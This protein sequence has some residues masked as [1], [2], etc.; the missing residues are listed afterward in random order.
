MR[1]MTRRTFLR[2]SGGLVVVVAGSAAGL[3][4]ACAPLQVIPT[5]TPPSPSPTDAPA[6]ATP[7][8]AATP[9]PVPTSRPTPAFEPD[10]EIE[11][12]AVEGVSQ[13]FSGAPTRVWRYEA[14]LVRGEA[15]NV[16]PIVESYLGPLIS[17]RKGQKVRVRFTNHLPEPTIV[18]WH[19]LLVPSRMDGHPRDAVGPGE[20]YIYEFEVANRA[21]SYW[22]HPHPDLLTGGQ[23]VR[24]LAGMLLVFDDEEAAAGLPSAD[25]DIPIVI[26]DRSFTSDNQI[27]YVEGDSAEGEVS[28]ERLMGFLGDRILIN[29]RPDFVLPVATRTYRLRLLNG[30]NSRVYKLAWSQG[31]PVTVIAT[32]GGLLEAP[33]NREYVMLGPGERIEVWAD[34]S[35]FPVGSEVTLQSR[36]F[37]GAEG[38]SLLEPGG[39]AT[40][41]PM[42]GM[43]HDVPAGEPQP[44]TEPTATAMADTGHGGM[45]GGT[46]AASPGAEPSP[47]AAEDMDMEHFSPT[48]P[49]GAP[50]DVLRIRVDRQEPSADVLPQSL[51]VIQR[52]KG[53]DATNAAAPRRFGLSLR[54]SQWLINGRPFEMEG[55]AADE[56]VKLGAVE[57]W[58]FVNELNPEEA[59]DKMGMVHPMHLHGVQFQVIERELLVPELRA[60]WDSVKDGYVDEGW[61]DTVLVMP[62]ERVRI[63]QRFEFPDLFVFHCHNLEH[64][65]L[66]MMRNYRAD[67]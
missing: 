53:Q 44:V 26:Q 25:Y 6:V 7:T 41:N 61:K 59:M 64:E 62:G 66:G 31:A 63:M 16:R 38:D 56:I 45:P 13:L 46:P 37:L 15:H 4:S 21:G 22:Y 19:G 17:L 24:G 12:R 28:M 51:S 23:V 11:L 3:L 65:D 1:R 58:D 20:T 10:V 30:S 40:A 8:P 52:F 47:T 67:P 54:N 43:G 32:D 34:F 35:Q 49:N 29:G 50:F 9:T 36:E 27:R 33:V 18:H 2:S 39:S 48:L 14:N 42:A 57:A 5:N 60:G 55:V